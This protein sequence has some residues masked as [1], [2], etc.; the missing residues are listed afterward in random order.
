M[1]G[2]VKMKRG[3]IYLVSVGNLDAYSTAEPTWILLLLLSLL[4]DKHGLAQKGGELQ[5]VDASRMVRGRCHVAKEPR[6]T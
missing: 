3:Q 1:V 2:T 6:A 5:R 4:Q